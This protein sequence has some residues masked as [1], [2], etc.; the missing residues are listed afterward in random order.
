MC[1]CV[2]SC[3]RSR[4]PGQGNEE[5]DGRIERDDDLYGE[6]RWFVLRI[7]RG[8]TNEGCSTEV[9]VER[10]FVAAVFSV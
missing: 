9:C 10:E 1:V 3:E 8:D 7:P 4:A 6:R 5:N 2:F